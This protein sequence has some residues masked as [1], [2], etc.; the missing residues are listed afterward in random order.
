MNDNREQILLIVRQMCED[1]LVLGTWGNV[2]VRN[3]EESMWITPSGMDYGSL[4]ADD[5]V[6]ISFNGTVLK[7][8]WKPS[9]EWML[10]AVLYKGR[11]DC[12]AIVHTH[13]TFATAFAVAR[14]AIPPVV[15]DCA[16]VVGGSVHVAEYALPGTE[17]LAK[18][19]LSA[20]ADRSAVLLANHGLVG[21]APTLSE[22]LKVC[23][24]VE[25]TAQTVLY[26]KMLGPVKSL[27]EED[28]RA[29]RSFYL[30]SY[31]PE[32]KEIS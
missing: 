10:H 28:I 5:L 26:A 16:Q 25:K 2:S 21:V 32:I 18:N 14:V 1:N 11:H 23:R 30:N 19:A 12:A 4:C 24:I 13:S 7:G 29:M 31:G 8:R 22:A 17:L 6:H 15:E 27:S 9:S 20:L 3:D